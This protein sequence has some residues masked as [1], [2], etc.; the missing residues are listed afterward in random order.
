MKKTGLI[1]LLMIFLGT[2]AAQAQPGW[3]K[4]VS[5]SVF[6]LKTFG[7][8]G[9]LLGSATGFVVG[10]NGEAVSCYAPFK[11]ASRAI[12]IDASGK[13]YEVD[14]MLGANE[15]Y[16]VAKFR[17]KTSKI[18]AVTIAAGKAVNSQSVWIQP[19][20]EVKQIVPGILVKTETFKD[21][22]DY[23][24]L[25]MVVDDQVNGAPL[26]NDAGEV[27]GLVQPSSTAKN[28]QCY[29][30][31]VRYAAQLSITGLSHNDPALRAVN[32][33]KD[34]PDTEE[35]AVLALYMGASSADS[36]AYAAM[37]DAFIAKFPKSSEGYMNRAQ[38]MANARRYAEADR[39][40][41]AALKT[42]DQTAGVHYRYS[43]M[44]LQDIAGRAATE[45][46]SWTLDKALQEAEE[47]DRATHD[48]LYVQQQASVLYA[49][50][51]YGEAYQ[52]YE[53]I[54]DSPL[55]SA[56][57]FYEASNCKAMLRD[58][59]AQ[60]ALLDSCVAQ[61]SQPYLKE[62]APYLLAR[63][64]V[65]LQTGR[66]REAVLDLNHYESLMKTQVNAR[67]Y[68]VRYQAE[69]GGRLYQQALNDIDR[70][71]R[72]DD[73]NSLYYAEKASLQLRVGQ[74]DEAIRT[75]TDCVR[76]APADSDGY[77]LLGAAQCQ[78]NQTAAGLANLRKAKE[79]GNG[80]ADALIEQ[81]S[82]K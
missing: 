8:D 75:A 13:E 70:A 80:Q 15:T 22:Y 46:G 61:F 39:D 50:K 47:A 55:R 34:L 74:Y 42:G 78:N 11:N 9:A 28:R 45:Q 32:I 67:F 48:P 7:A 72:M 51:R 44:I 5:K 4:K 53:Q 64:Q 27:M 82:K 23:Y 52:K 73:A 12:A 33:R 25:S 16:D 56:G 30:V 36:L 81:Y 31:G 24:T 21:S 37:V 68:Y 65:S 2:V 19:Y 26:L 20:R 69:L 18:P 60:A 49:L 6:A 66:Y 38:L 79:L 41:E 58:T 10:A 40:M 29:A 76:L 17:L 35:Q 57:L 1:Y 3:A 43:R 14:C 71:V 62:A 59:V 54:F 77:L 63:A